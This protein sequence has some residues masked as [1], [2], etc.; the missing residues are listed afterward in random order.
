MAAAAILHCRIR[1]FSLADGVRGPRRKAVPNFVQIGRSVAEILRFFE[2][3][4]WP[5]PP[6]Y[7]F[8][9]ENFLLANGVHRIET[10]QHAKYRQNQSIGCEDIK[11]F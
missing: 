3:S 11:I 6:S 7:I 5:P 10:H 1:K 4:R 9:M 2:F 8:E